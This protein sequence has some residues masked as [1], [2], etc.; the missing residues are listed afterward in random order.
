MAIGLNSW[1]LVFNAKYNTQIEIGWKT[2][3][4]SW[5]A[6]KGFNL[7]KSLLDPFRQTVR[8]SGTPGLTVARCNETLG[9][10]S[11]RS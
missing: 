8:Y 6:T 3:R 2:G 9:C 1:A 10:R 7:P 5:E 11:V 4:T